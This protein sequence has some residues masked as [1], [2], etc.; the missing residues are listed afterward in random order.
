MYSELSCSSLFIN[1]VTSCSR[2]G[3]IFVEEA[4]VDAL[5]LETPRIGV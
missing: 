1:G 3:E 2:L 5:I 4:E